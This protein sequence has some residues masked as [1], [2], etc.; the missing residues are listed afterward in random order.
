MLVNQTSRKWLSLFWNLFV[1]PALVWSPSPLEVNMWLC[2]LLHDAHQFVWIYVVWSLVWSRADSGLFKAF[3]TKTA[4]ICKT[5]KAVTADGGLEF[6]KASSCVD[7]SSFVW[8][9]DASPCQQL[10]QWHSSLCSPFHHHLIT[11]WWFY[12]ALH[13][14]SRITTSVSGNLNGQGS[15]RN[16]K[17]GGLEVKVYWK[18]CLKHQSFS[19]LTLFLF[20]NSTK[21]THTLCTRGR[22][23]S[24]T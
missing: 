11:Y 20:L 7:W 24:K 17:A 14:L 15:A 8:L 3:V 5:I 16:F 1:F 18:S 22:H 21:V 12:S 6:R 19:K 2:E 4:A 23:T 13:T 9:F 10:T